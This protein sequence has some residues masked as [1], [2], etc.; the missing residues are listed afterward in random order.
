MNQSNQEDTQLQEPA[1]LLEVRPV[2]RCRFSVSF[3]HVA[4]VVGVAKVMMSLVIFWR[5]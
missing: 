4:V 1:E 3:H 5:C 2:C